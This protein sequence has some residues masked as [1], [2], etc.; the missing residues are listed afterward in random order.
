M[1]IYGM[2]QPEGKVPRPD[3]SQLAAA[4]A[5]LEGQA[6]KTSRVNDPVYEAAMRNMQR[7][8]DQPGGY[9]PRLVEQRKQQRAEREAYFKSRELLGSD[10]ANRDLADFDRQTTSLLE[11]DAARRSQQRMGTYNI[12]A[13]AASPEQ[14]SRTFSQLANLG[15]QGAQMEQTGASTNA[16]LQEARRNQLLSTGGN[17]FGRAIATN[18]F[19]G[20][21][22]PRTGKKRSGF[23]A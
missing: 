14:T 2:M 12:A 20:E 11:D 18:P 16:Q 7:E 15:I 1:G 23:A 22:D 13:G 3:L 6:G 19:E 5:A 8:L 10:I 17:I 9:D 4:R 21:Y